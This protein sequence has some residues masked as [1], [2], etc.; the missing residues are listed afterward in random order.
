MAS[1]SAA[2]GGAEVQATASGAISRRHEASRRPPS[3]RYAPCQAPA[4]RATSGAS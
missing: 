2:I 4:A 1:E 3:L